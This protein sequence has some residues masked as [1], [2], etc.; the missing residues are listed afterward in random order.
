MRI[1]ELDEFE[2]RLEDIIG[3]R[4]GPCDL[5]PFVCDG[6]PLECRIFIVGINPATPLGGNFWDYWR[7]S[8]PKRGFDKSA[9]QA[10]YNAKRVEE[11]DDKSSRTRKVIDLILKGLEM[12]SRWPCLE[13]NIYATEKE[14]PGNLKGEEKSTREFDFLLEA[15]EPAIILTHGKAPEEHVAKKNTAAKIISVPH[16]SRYWSDGMALSLGKH[17]GKLVRLMSS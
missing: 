8:E 3:K 13:T 16:F 17:L 10:A 6:S 4:S 7:W 12:A 11:G 9:W 1:T 15:L 5:R 2:R 14:T